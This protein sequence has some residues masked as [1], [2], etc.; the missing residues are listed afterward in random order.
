MKVALYSMTQTLGD[1]GQKVWTASE[2]GDVFARVERVVDET[3]SDDNL[4]ASA[5]LTVTI[6]KVPE[7]T[8]RWRVVIAGKT[9][10]IGAIDSISRWSPL[11]TL[12]LHAID[13]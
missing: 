13:G 11:C 9:Y 12:T 3:V 8:T 6:Y 4:E 10:E 1:E 7:L 2:Y 5:G